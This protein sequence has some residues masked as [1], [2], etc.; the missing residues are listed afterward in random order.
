M[1]ENKSE[2]FYLKNVQE[3]LVL[4]YP[5]HLIASECWEKNYGNKEIHISAWPTYDEKIN[6]EDKGPNIVRLMVKEA[7][8][9]ARLGQSE[10][11]IF[12]QCLEIEKH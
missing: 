6:Q 9:D 12:N 2:K 3:F 5:L 11:K 1:H 4:I 8:L 7:L 10:R